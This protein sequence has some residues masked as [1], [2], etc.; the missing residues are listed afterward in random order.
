MIGLIVLRDNPIN[1]KSCCHFYKIIGCCKVHIYDYSVNNLHWTVKQVYVFCCKYVIENWIAFN[2]FT[3][4][5]ISVLNLF[6]AGAGNIA[7]RVAGILSK[8]Q[9]F[10]LP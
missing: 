9:V 8:K 4:K 10:K 5:P 1:V 3:S 2:L 7:V 6:G